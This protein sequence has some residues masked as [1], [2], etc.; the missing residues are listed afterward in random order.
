MDNN[1]YFIYYIVPSFTDKCNVRSCN[2]L[3]GPEQRH[4]GWIRRDR[5]GA[6]QTLGSGRLH[7]AGL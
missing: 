6:D 2:F 7:S 1:G 5:T 4:T 3:A